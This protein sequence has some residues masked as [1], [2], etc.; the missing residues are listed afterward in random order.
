[1]TNAVATVL[2][3]SLTA[4]F[5]IAVLCAARV[6]LERLH[7]P[8]WISYALWAVAGFRLAVP[9]TFES[10][11]SL[12][13][14]NLPS[15]AAPVRQY[16]EALPPIGTPERIDYMF[17]AS[18]PAGVPIWT[19]YDAFAAVW[20]AGIA[21]MLLYAVISYVRLIRRKDSVTTPFVYGF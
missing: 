16:Y 19:A 8:K 15:V 13:P 20:L 18:H 2:N 11:L 4:A 17:A 5:V 6:V 3:M 10:V 7:A 14:R 21:V 9:F 12:I 1:M